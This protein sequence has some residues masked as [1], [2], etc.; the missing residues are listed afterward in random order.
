MFLEIA[1]FSIFG[2]QMTQT[3][4]ATE[5]GSYSMVEFFYCWIASVLICFIVIASG[6]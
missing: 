6:C 1:L 3:G 2:K 5:I 4:M